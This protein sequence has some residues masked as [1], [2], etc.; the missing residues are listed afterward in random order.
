MT[1]TEL[2]DYCNELILDFKKN[3]LGGFLVLVTDEGMASVI[4][5][6][7]WGILTADFKEKKVSLTDLNEESSMEKWLEKAE[8]TL[9]Y[10][11]AVKQSCSDSTEA[12][13][14]IQK[15]L[16]KVL[17]QLTETIL[18]AENKVTVH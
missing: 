7:E 9:Y 12:F 15:V 14:S 3:K 4:I 18:N 11:E 8:K 13:N 16:N 2:N 6:P 1:E 5:L 10:L 17:E